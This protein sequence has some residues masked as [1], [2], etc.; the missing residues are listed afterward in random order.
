MR[1]FNNLIKSGRTHL[2]AFPGGTVNQLNLVF[3]NV[4][5]AG[6]DLRRSIAEMTRMLSTREV[7][8]TVSPDENS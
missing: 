5:K 8:I 3:K 4:G 2:K 7:K 6:S 1:E